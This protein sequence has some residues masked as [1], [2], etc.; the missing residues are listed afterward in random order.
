[1]RISAKQYAEGLAA[2]LRQA[3]PSAQSELVDRFIRIVAKD[4]ET[5]LFPAILRHMARI[6]EA[7]GSGRHIKIV[8]AR[9]VSSE[10]KEEISHEAE[11]I[12]GESP[13]IQERIDPSVLGGAVFHVG[14]ERVDASIKGK[15]REFGT[16]LRSEC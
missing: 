3:A 10:A 15:L 6:E 7:N 14:T 11:R 12:F 13:V 4:R 8:Y 2:S 9:R 1:M 5:K 16:F